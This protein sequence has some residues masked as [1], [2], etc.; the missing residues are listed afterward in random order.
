MASCPS[1]RLVVP[2]SDPRSSARIKYAFSAYAALYGVRCV[3]AGSADVTVGYGEVDEPVDVSLSATYCPRPSSAPAPTPVWNDG[4]PCFHPTGRRGPDVLGE[5]FEWLGAPHELA[6]TELDAVGRIPP[7]HTLAGTHGL[8]RMVPW[9][10]RWAARLHAQV[11][12]ALPGL[13]TRPPS[14]FGTRPTFVASHDLDHLSGSRRVN[15]KRII[16][17]AGIAVI[18][19]RDP[20]TGLRILAEATRHTLRRE[21]ALIGVPR[22]LAGES[23]RGVRATYTVIAESTHRRDGGYRLTDDFVRNTLDAIAA[24]GH[25]IAVHGSYRSLEVDGQLA[26]EYELLRSAGY[27]VTGSRQHWLRYRGSELFSAIETAGGTWDSTAGHPDDVGFR[28]GAAFPFLPYDF[29][30]EAPHPVVEIPLVIMERALCSVTDDPAAWPSAALDVLRAASA[31]S[32][33]GVAVLWH[34]DAFTGTT[35]PTRLADAYWAVLDAGDNWMPAHEVAQAGR[36][37][38]RAAGALASDDRTSSPATL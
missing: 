16:K 35:F 32:W 36:D 20:R 21:P 24:D 33:G 9:V 27:A 38:W 26:R 19:D 4:M 8:D 34:D 29:S 23:E 11:L 7:A 28:H 10:N 30:R 31:D 22:L 15:A 1:V 6:C 13:P 5:I 37:R 17:N 18:G 25:E 12:G 2:R 14:P 3:N